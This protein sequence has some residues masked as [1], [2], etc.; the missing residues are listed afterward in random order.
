MNHCDRSNVRYPDLDE[1]MR[2]KRNIT[3]GEELCINYGK[4]W[5]ELRGYA[6]SKPK[7]L[8]YDDDDDNEE[9]E[10]VQAQI[11]PGYYD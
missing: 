5:W 3:K 6:K 7:R 9:E 4:A 10:D 8:D 2:A 11:I 1:V